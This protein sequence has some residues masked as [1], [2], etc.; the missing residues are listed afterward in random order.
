MKNDRGPDQ[1]TESMEAVAGTKTVKDPG[2]KTK[3]VKDPGAKT[4]D[5]VEVV[6]SIAVDATIALVPDHAPD[7]G[8]KTND[9]VGAVTVI[10]EAEVAISIVEVKVAIV[11]DATVALVPDH[12]TEG[13]DDLHRGSGPERLDDLDEL[14]EATIHHPAN[15]VNLHLMSN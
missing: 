4:N 2:A 3:T 10:D 11:V 13:V 7:P 9:G 14:E 15:Y 6:I 5:E 12:A 8:A 1:E